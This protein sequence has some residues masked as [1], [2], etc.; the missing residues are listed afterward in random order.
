MIKVLHFGISTHLGGI[1]TYSYKLARNFDM[2]KYHFDFLYL[3]KNKPCFFQELSDLGCG[4]I[5][6]SSRRDGYIKYII[7]LDKIFKKGNWDI[8]HLH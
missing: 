1:E 8:V 5:N 4:F 6:I 2:S 7:D 3:G